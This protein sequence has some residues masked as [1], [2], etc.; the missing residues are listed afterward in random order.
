MQKNKQCSG[1]ARCNPE[2]G[3]VVESN[4]RAGWRKCR[5]YEV[6]IAKLRKKMRVEH[7]KSSRE[8]MSFRASSGRADIQVLVE[9]CL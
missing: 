7:C 6:K 4:E 3:K 1:C 9:S 8:S 2:I 5:S